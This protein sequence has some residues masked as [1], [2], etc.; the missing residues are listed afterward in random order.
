MP[1]ALQP[2]APGHDDRKCRFLAPNPA[3]DRS[4]I[5]PGK[6]RSRLPLFLCLAKERPVFST[7]VKCR[8]CRDHALLYRPVEDGP[9]T[10]PS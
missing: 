3:F 5:A 8:Y 7:M 6:D 10:P 2:K 4:Q 1:D 9:C